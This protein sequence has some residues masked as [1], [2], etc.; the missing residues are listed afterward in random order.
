MR[1]RKINQLATLLSAKALRA[2]KAAELALPL[3]VRRRLA[4]SPAAKEALRLADFAPSLVRL[5][6]SGPDSE[7]TAN[8]A[9]ALW[10]MADGSPRNKDC[11]R[12]AGAIPELVR[13]VGCGWERRCALKAAGALGSLA[14]A[15]SNK[16]IVLAAGAA[17]LL[18][19][20]L[21]AGRERRQ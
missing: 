10:S 8:A 11:V 16:D 2:L 12:E 17:P 19:A 4:R 14:F 20:L 13:L 9:A 1:R 21:R 18:T 15:T 6:A 7:A 3:D 5:L